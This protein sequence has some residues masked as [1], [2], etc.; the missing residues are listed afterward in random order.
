MRIDFHAHV[1]PGADHG[2]ENVEMSLQQL[3]LAK[4]AGIDVVVITPHFYP[5]KETLE[6]FLKRRERTYCMLL[7]AAEGQAFPKLLLGAEIYLCPGLQELDGLEQLCISGSRTLLFEMPREKSRPDLFETL[8]EVREFRN[9]EPIMAHIDR[10]EQHDVDRL[11]DMELPAQ[12][13]AGGLCSFWK[14]KKLLR[15]VQ[16]NRIYAL[17]SDIHGTAIGYTEYQKAEAFLKSDFDRIMEKSRRLLR[18]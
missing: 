10:Y 15:Y 16:A 4:E 11:L 8:D 12:L 14:R 1:L 3:K 5:N 13:N 2:C 18:L 7:Q 17:G 9:L 6:R